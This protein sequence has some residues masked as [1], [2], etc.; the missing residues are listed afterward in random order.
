MANVQNVGF[1]NTTYA[2][3]QAAIERQKQMAAILQQQAL[4]QD[5]GTQ[6]IGGFAV[7]Q[8]GFA[9]LAKALQG[10]AAGGA[11]RKAAASEQALADK[12]RTDLSSVLMGAF[13][14]PEIAQPSAELGGGPGAPAVAGADP[15]TQARLLLSHPQTAP[16][17]MNLIQQQQQRAE[18]ERLLASILGPQGG[19]QAPAGVAPGTAAATGA[20]WAQ[21]PQAAPAQQGGLN[22]QVM[23]L[24][25]SGDPGLQAIG[26]A[27]QDKLMEDNKIIA[28]R[29]GAPGIRQGSGAVV[30]QPTPAVPTGMGLKVG[31]DGGFSAYNVPGYAGAE[32]ALH[33]ID[34]PD[35]PMVEIPTG[36]AGETLKLTQ[37]EY[38]EFQRTGQPPARL[39]GAPRGGVGGGG[40][41]L[42]VSPGS[43][44]Q[45]EAK[46]T[47]K[48]LGQYTSKVQGD[49]ANAA[50]SNRYLDTMEMAARDFTPGKLAPM[51]SSLI[52]WAQSMN[53]PLSEDDKKAAG[54]MQALASMAIKMAG[55]ATRQADAQPS[56]LQYFKILESMPTEARTAD[57]FNKIVAYLRDANNYSI[58]KQQNLQQWRQSHGGSAEGFEAAWPTM[59]QKLPFVWN[60][61]QR[62]ADLKGIVGSTGPKPNTDA[63]V[64]KWLRR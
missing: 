17:G 42:G 60:Q 64:D 48:E 28:L 61:G 38:L 39:G 44:A 52:Q 45:A 54:S 35:A 16:L 32:T 63:L 57:G 30:A 26:K 5:G 12:S 10:M 47:G 19:S 7:P 3:D 8:S 9:P 2:A 33:N 50:V 40:R 27:M 11:Q 59:A 24:L 1:A 29:P 21:A 25:A 36:K 13:G 49:A 4:Q 53:L 15:Q 51:Q 14:R 62:A 56:Q 20:P 46:E 43:A 58:A 55:Q 34:K 22:P 23:A 41:G 18:R 31:A 37:P 6:V